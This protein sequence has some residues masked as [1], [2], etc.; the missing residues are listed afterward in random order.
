MAL[1]PLFSIVGKIATRLG[2]VERKNFKVL[3][4]TLGKNKE[5]NDLK[6]AGNFLIQPKAQN[7]VDLD[8]QLD[9]F[10]VAL[11]SGPQR[12]LLTQ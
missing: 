12:Y 9:S 7:K 3:Q 10:T 6:S 5:Q 8:N 2:E 4:F 11:K 1:P